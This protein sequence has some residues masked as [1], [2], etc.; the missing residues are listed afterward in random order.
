MN[1]KEFHKFLFSHSM[2][3]DDR[4]LDSLVRIGHDVNGGEDARDNISALIAFA[5]FRDDFAS[6]LLRKLGNKFYGF[7]HAGDFTL[8]KINN[9]IDLEDKNKEWNDVSEKDIPS[10]DIKLLQSLGIEFTV[11]EENINDELEIFEELFTNETDVN[12]K[13]SE[14]P[15]ANEVNV[16][17][18]IQ[19]TSNKNTQSAEKEVDVDEGEDEQEEVGYKYTLTYIAACLGDLG[20]ED[21]FD[22]QN[23]ALKDENCDEIYGKRINDKSSIVFEDGVDGWK[24]RDKFVAKDN[25]LTIMHSRKMPAAEDS[26]FAGLSGMYNRMIGKGQTPFIFNLTAKTPE[27][28]E[29]LGASIY[30]LCLSDDAV[31]NEMEKN[32]TGFI[33]NGK[34]FSFCD[35]KKTFSSK[36]STKV[37]NKVVGESE[38]KI[39]E[40][41][42]NCCSEIFLEIFNDVQEERK[43]ENSKNFQSAT[44]KVESFAKDDDDHKQF[45][46]LVAAVQNAGR[47]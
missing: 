19:G 28:A 20:K 9:F 27:F 45:G 34:T 43:A 1:E 47:S 2:D 29:S 26:V 32:I 17:E 6:E 5:F 42:S 31:S 36:I 13:I 39:Q 11:S 41:F 4:V 30:R 16:S 25:S 15:V 40:F 35:F 22:V 23:P 44:E 8:D 14:K 33:L 10:E 46:D 3:L 24:T 7:L 37:N 12:E 38:E 18:V 21:K